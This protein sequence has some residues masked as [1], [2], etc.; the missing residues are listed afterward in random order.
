MSLSIQIF[1][2]ATICNII[3]DINKTLEN[4][5]PCLHYTHIYTDKTIDHDPLNA[6]RWASEKAIYT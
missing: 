2:E 4:V 1:M 5:M 3:T 6:T